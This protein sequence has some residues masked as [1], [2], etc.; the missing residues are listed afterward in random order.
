M[1]Y[2][3]EAR[4]P[5]R[6]SGR[7]FT[8]KELAL[9]HEVVETCSGL[10]R[11]ELAQTVCELLGWKRPSG[12]LKARE[13]REFL[14]KLDS[15]GA[16]KLPAKAATRPVGSRTR[17]PMTIRGERG[18]D[19]VGEVGEFSPIEVEAV[20]T[21]NQRLLFRELVGRHHYLG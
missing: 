9:I 14:E 2:G 4:T 5:T 13:C 6:F 16:L 7:Q 19:L 20:E 1:P 11:K 8:P 10:S 21:A 12:G 3:T 17:V 15:A 18:R